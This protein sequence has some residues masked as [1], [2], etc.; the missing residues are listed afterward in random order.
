[1]A[2]APAATG[3]VAAKGHSLRDRQI[4]SLKRV[5]NLNESLDQK[6]ENDAHANGLAP[7]VPILT[8]QGDP[9]WKVLV[10]DDLGTHPLIPAPEGWCLSNR[11]A[12]GTTPTSK[13]VM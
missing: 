7:A 9:I 11:T 5:L 10:F 2:S 4:S 3:P 8:S 6:E 13:A 12:N 1:M